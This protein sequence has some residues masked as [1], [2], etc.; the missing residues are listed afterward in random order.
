MIKST[1]YNRPRGVT[2][3]NGVGMG[4]DKNDIEGLSERVRSLERQNRIYSEE[5]VKL[6]ESI[7]NKGDLADLKEDVLRK[8]AVIQK[9]ISVIVDKVNYT[10]K[11]QLTI[12]NSLSRLDQKTIR[13]HDSVWDLHYR[14]CPLEDDVKDLKEAVFNPMWQPKR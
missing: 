10:T 7:R 9:R 12:L 3:G 14:I 1:D 11:E 6:R 8:D 13:L 5:L 4:Q 2:W